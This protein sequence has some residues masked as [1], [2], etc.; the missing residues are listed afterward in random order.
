MSTADQLLKDY[1]AAT[2][3][4]QSVPWSRP[5]RY[6]IS[7]SCFI[8]RQLNIICRIE[9]TFNNKNLESKWKFVSCLSKLYGCFLEL[10]AS[11]IGVHHAGLSIGDRRAT[12]TLYLNKILRVVVC[13]SVSIS[14]HECSHRFEMSQ[15][16]LAV[17]VNLRTLSP[18][19][20][21]GSV[22]NI[23]DSCAHCGD[24]RREDISKQ[25]VSRVLRSRHHAND[26]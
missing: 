24:Q 12:E 8:E 23:I 10:A 26:G 14:L 4:K 22:S 3:K 13:T 11:G 17:G 16:T 18:I 7:C 25:R 20:S 5:T 2:E 19:T 21:S 6:T 15:Q 1:T 9:Q